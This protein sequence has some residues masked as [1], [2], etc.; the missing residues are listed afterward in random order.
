[1]VSSE[2]L[3][4]KSEKMHAPKKSFPKGSSEQMLFSLALRRKKRDKIDVATMIV[5]G[6]SLQ[7]TLARY[8]VGFVYLREKNIGNQQYN[9]PDK[10][11]KQY[12]KYDKPFAYL[13][14]VRH[15]D[16]NVRNQ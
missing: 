14:V 1:M 15:F 2:N 7:V 4:K 12:E 3:Q 8:G 6:F 16:D 5:T 13:R 11:S 9:K 10:K